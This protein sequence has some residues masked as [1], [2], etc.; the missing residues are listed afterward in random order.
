M[1]KMALEISISPGDP[2]GKAEGRL[3][4]L[5]LPCTDRGFWKQRVS[6]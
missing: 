6:M 2:V 4:Y 1:Y 5:G 3:I